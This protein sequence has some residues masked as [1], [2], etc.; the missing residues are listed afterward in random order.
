[1]RRQLVVTSMLLLLSALPMGGQQGSK[2]A[3]ATGSAAPQTPGITREQADQILQE[4]RDIH[5]LLERQNQPPGPPRAAQGNE[6]VRLMLTDESR[7]LGKPEAPFVIVEFLDYQCP[8]CA[9]YHRDTFPEIRQKYIDTGLARYV[10]QDL[11]LSTLHPY[12]QLAAEAVRCAGDQKRLWQLRDALLA[13][14]REVA[15]D[16]IRH[17]AAAAGLDMTAFDACTSSRKFQS[18]VQADAR[19][20]AGLGITGTPT[21]VVGK[22]NAKE[23]TGVKLVGAVPIGMIDSEVAQIAKKR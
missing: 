22:E 6:T 16:G 17:K 23:V 8:F 21:F 15:P 10:L 5:R 18:A 13:D 1:M 11:P 4:L 12:A 7:V 3:G 2:T 19:V 14:S 9:K 20:A